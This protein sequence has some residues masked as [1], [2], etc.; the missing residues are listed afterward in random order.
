MTSTS[1]RRRISAEERS[2]L[3]SL[4]RG[5]GLTQ[6]KFAQQQGIKLCTLQRWLYGSGGKKN[7]KARFQEVPVTSLLSPPWV[8][9]LSLNGGL[10]LRLSAGAKADWICT[11]VNA[12]GSC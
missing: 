6:L 2:R 7:A 10:T 11:V 5:S 12:L 9:E 4:F 1:R 3:V 8:A